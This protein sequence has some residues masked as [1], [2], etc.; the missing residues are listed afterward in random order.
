MPLATLRGVLGYAEGARAAAV[1]R[2]QAAGRYDR[3]DPL[4]VAEATRSAALLEAGQGGVRQKACHLQHQRPHGLP[5]PRPARR[6]AR[7][8]VIE[9]HRIRRGFPAPG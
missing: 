4:L 9:P 5:C 3:A 8:Q 6:V 1:R 7:D 2:A